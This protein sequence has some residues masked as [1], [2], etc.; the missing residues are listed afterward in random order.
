MAL[1]ESDGSVD[2]ELGFSTSSHKYRT[3]VKRAESGWVAQNTPVQS[4]YLLVQ[5]VMLCHQHVA[6]NW[7]LL[8]G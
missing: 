1:N 3:G 2:V 7:S 6:L 5:E 8:I 4:S